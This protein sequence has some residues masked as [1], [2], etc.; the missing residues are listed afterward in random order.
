MCDQSLQFKES[1]T[2]PW[3]FLS[4]F[5][6]IIP[7]PR[8]THSPSSPPGAHRG[9][10]AG[11]AVC[12]VSTEKC[13][14]AQ[15]SGPFRV[16]QGGEHHTEFILKSTAW[17]R[18]A[19][20]CHPGAPGGYAC[21]HPGGGQGHSL[22][23]AVSQ[24]RGSMQEPHGSGQRQSTWKQGKW[25]APWV[26]PK[27]KQKKAF[28]CSELS[29][30]EGIQIADVRDHFISCLEVQIGAQI[31]YFKG[32]LQFS[33][34]RTFAFLSAQHPPHPL[35]FF[36]LSVHSF[37]QRGWFK[38]IWNT[39]SALVYEDT[40]VNK[41]L[42]LP[43]V[44]YLDKIFK[45][46]DVNSPYNNRS[47]WLA[48]TQWHG[49][50]VFSGAFTKEKVLEPGSEGYKSFPRQT[51]VGENF[52]QREQHTSSQSRKSVTPGI[53]CALCLV[54][55]HWYID[56]RVSSEIGGADG[57]KSLRT[58][59]LRVWNLSWRQWWG[60]TGSYPQ[61]RKIWLYRRGIGRGNTKARWRLAG[62]CFSR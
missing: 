25:K 38:H 43:R 40:I 4:A 56:L 9:P 36:N 3:C 23:S 52:K 49:G 61:F 35:F 16:F 21:V 22:S 12:V 48:G 27:V 33:D 62:K 1:W 13:H 18:T 60:I 11:P 14:S 31:T 2:A 45:S 6:N 47:N 5:V 46:S 26:C 7:A 29:I 15:P 58:L 30:T 44:S 24:C 53:V 20:L 8:P 59:Y 19:K 42:P 34:S 51:W 57:V 41:M 10:R 28:V 50:K 55:N 39:K 54:A 32:H 17:I 37:I